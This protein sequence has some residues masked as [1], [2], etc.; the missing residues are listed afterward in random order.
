M[1]LPWPSVAF[2]VKDYPKDGEYR[3][4]K[5]TSRIAAKIQAYARARGLAGGDLVFGMPDNGPMFKVRP[6][7]DRLGRTEP[8]AA[9][10]R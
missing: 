7:P 4:L 10:R 1:P 9:G 3:R 2:L 6:N 8:N 5:L